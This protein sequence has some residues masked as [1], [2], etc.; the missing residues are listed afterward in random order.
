MFLRI[1]IF[2]VVVGSTFCKVLINVDQCSSNEQVVVTNTKTYCCENLKD[3]VENATRSVL[4]EYIARTK[5]TAGPTPSSSPVTFPGDCQG[6]LEQGNIETGVYT[7]YLEGS[8]TSA[9][10][11]RCD[12]ETDNGG[13][14][15]FQ[16]R[17]SAS[18]FN[19]TWDEYKHGFG[20]LDGNFWLGNDK[21]VSLCSD[22]PCMLRIDMEWG[23]ET[24]YA[25]YSRFSVEKESR[26]YT[27]HV[28]GYN[29]TAGD[30]LAY[31][32]NREFSTNDRDNDASVTDCAKRFLG[33][34]WYNSCHYANM[35]GDYGNTVFGKGM[36]WY[37]WTD[38]YGSLSMTEM[39]IR[40]APRN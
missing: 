31:H 1:S 35:N 5:Y 24:R 10:D 22:E 18:D 30:S 19:K 39:K 15:V 11:V 29:G 33:G 12:M 4:D 9:F 17:V 14:T 13:W 32:D 6:V 16:R 2:L 7:V 38:H 3:I 28:D 23:G 36:N 37:T 34:W 40:R 27:L 20:D 8:E 21:I 26:N 25:Q